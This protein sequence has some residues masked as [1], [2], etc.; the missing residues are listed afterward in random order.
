MKYLARV[1]AFVVL[2]ASASARADDQILEF[3]GLGSIL[4]GMTVPQ[5]EKALGRKL[6]PLDKSDGV[7]RE[8]CWLTERADGTEPWVT[9]MVQNRK[10]VRI[11]VWQDGQGL[12]P[13]TTVSG[14][15]IGSSEQVVSEKYG[16]ALQSSGHPSMG[17]SGH[18]ATVHAPDGKHGLLFETVH[19]SVVNMRSGVLKALYLAET[20]L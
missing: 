2:S 11:D 9:Y 10:I 14:I 15:R 16:A 5:A 3:N 12:P 20:C 1:F 7:S 6:K 13:V 19:G 18:Y 8:V 4:V 17:A